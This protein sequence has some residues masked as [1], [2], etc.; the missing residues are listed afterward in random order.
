M[1]QGNRKKYIVITI[2]F[3][4]LVLIGILMGAQKRRSPERLPVTQKPTIPN[5]IKEELDIKTVFDKK[6]FSFPKKAPLVK[7]ETR[8]P[9]TESDVLAKASEMGFGKNYIISNDVKRGKTYIW[10]EGPTSLTIYSRINKVVYTSVTPLPT[11]N[12]NLSNDELIEK[13]TTFLTEN[14]LFDEYELSF[15]FIVFLDIKSEETRPVSR[16]KA[17]AFKVNF[18]PI[19]SEI[20]LVMID[21]TESPISVWIAPDG[22][23]FKAEAINVGLVT[24]SE[25]EVEL[26]NYDEFIKALDE[27]IVVSL[28]DGNLFMGD[29]PKNSVKKI[30]LETVEL[31][32]LADSEVAQTYHPIYLLEGSSEISSFTDPVSI[33][34]YLP[35]ISELR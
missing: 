4:V 3:F 6:D 20:K 30:K 11:E 33:T 23:V 5:Y 8:E 28:D 19:E 32:Y 9:L 10:R 12:K 14:S 35:A 18:S 26:K 13:A 17:S 1:I 2:V 16:E 34:L 31:A 22:T 7:L 15:S 21:P 27:A 25:E 24:F 29:L